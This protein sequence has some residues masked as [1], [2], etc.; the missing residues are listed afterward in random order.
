M[1]QMKQTTCPFQIAL[2]FR[3]T[4]A[5]EGAIGNSGWQYSNT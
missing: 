4:R 3:S 1:M 2:G 5:A